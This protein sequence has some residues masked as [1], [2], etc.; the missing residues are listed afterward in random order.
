IKRYKLNR[1]NKLLELVKINYDENNNP[2]EQNFNNEYFIRFE[3]DNNGNAIKEERENAHGLK[4][5]QG[6]FIYNEDGL[7]L[8]ERTPDQIKKFNYEFFK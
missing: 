1:K 6:L 4:E 7:L 8:E 2:V 5:Y 3:Y